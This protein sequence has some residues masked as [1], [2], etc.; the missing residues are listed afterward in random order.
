MLAVNIDIRDRL[1]NYQTG[2]NRHIE[3]AEGSDCK[4]YVNFMVNQLA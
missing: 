3:F 4:I 2:N 1:I